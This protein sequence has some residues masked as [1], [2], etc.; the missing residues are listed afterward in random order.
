MQPAEIRTEDLL[1]RPWRPSDTAAVERAHKHPSLRSW[2]AEQDSP[3]A[4]ADDGARILRGVF[5]HHGT[6]LGGVHL[7]DLHR[8]R[9]TVQLGYWTAPWARGRRVAERAS[10]A[11]LDWAFRHLGLLRVDWRAT[12]GNHPARLTALRLGFRIIGE[13]PGPPAPRWL[14]ALVPGE[15]TG[16]GHEL[17]ETVRRQARVFGGRPPVL[18]A[19]PVRLRPPADGDRPAI[20]AAYSD[21]EVRRWYGVAEPWTDADSAGFVRREAPLEWLRGR[22]VVLAVAGPGDAWAPSTCGCTSTT[23]ARVR[24][25]S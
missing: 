15:L 21:P 22:E 4:A 25:V 7:I 11:L 14:A 20:T 16:P 23:A 5:D 13:C 24:S 6:P 10:R 3:W 18:D 8:S 19:G 9:R 12:V 17:S 2:A 1:L